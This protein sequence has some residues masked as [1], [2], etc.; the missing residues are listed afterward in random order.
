[1]RR[2]DH[3]VA[4]RQP[5]DRAVGRRRL[6]AGD[7]DPGA[8]DEAGVEGALQRLLI[9]ESAPRRIDQ[10]GLFIHRGEGFRVDHILRPGVE[11][12]MQRQNVGGGENLVESDK[13]GF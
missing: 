6:G 10:K 3:V 1:M 7:V 11:R 2:D 4:P 12:T 5:H 8:G 13:A 9:D